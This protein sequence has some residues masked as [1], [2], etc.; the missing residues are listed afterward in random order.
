MRR[1]YAR[2]TSSPGAIL[3]YYPLSPISYHV[4]V[5]CNFLVSHDTDPE[6]EE[7]FSPSFFWPLILLFLSFFFTL[8]N[9]FR[10]FRAFLMDA[11]QFHRISWRV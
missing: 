9:R 7:F 6:R 5:C 3:D 1:L 4:R 2:E 10:R 8:Y 11:D